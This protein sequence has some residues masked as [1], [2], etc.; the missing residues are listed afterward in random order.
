LLDRPDSTAVTTDASV[1]MP[2]NPRA[3]YL[4]TPMLAVLWAASGLAVWSQSP[5]QN[6]P[7]KNLPRKNVKS[8]STRGKQTFASTC[9]GCHGLD[10]RGSERAPNIVE[11]P[12]VQ[13]LSDAQI[14]HIVENGVPGTG[15][16]A[17]HSLASTDVRGVVTYLRSL[18]GAKINVKLPGHP[19]RGET[20]FFG[21]AGCFRCHMAAGKGG[22]I[23]SDLSS[24]ARTHAVEQIRSA[25]ASPTPASNGQARMVTATTHAGEK[26]VGRIR[27]EDNFSLQLQMLDGTFFFV[28]KSDLERLDSSQ[29]LMHSDYGST[30]SS[31]ELND[32][33]SY[34]MRV[35]GVKP[36]EAVAKTDGFEDP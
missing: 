26:Y 15:M 22:F 27:D 30:L 36:G 11:N 33:I 12:K 8:V 19:I 31:N 18:Q 4:L 13:R 25:I 21:N 1:P 20:I 9:A 23:A 7:Q 32:V 35:S 10:A 2:L 34:L 17:F 29:T 6:V 24:Y 14:S 16:P 5:Q 28:E 3:L